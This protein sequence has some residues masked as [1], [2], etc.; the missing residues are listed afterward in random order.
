M[1][2]S[3]NARNQFSESQIIAL[4]LLGDAQNCSVEPASGKTSL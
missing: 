1:R 3:H 2:C 4:G